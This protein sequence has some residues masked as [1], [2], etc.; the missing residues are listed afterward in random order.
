VD[1]GQTLSRIPEGRRFVF[2]CELKKIPNESSRLPK[3]ETP[4]LSAHEQDSFS[5]RPPGR[6]S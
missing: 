1:I 3:N 2:S 6:S 4:V 5:D